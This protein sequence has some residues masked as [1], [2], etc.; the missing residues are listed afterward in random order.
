MRSIGKILCIVTSATLLSAM[1]V[2]AS[3]GSQ[4]VT[5]L[6]SEQT[7]ADVVQTTGGLEFIQQYTTNMNFIGN[8]KESDFAKEFHIREEKRGELTGNWYLHPYNL[9]PSFCKPWSEFARRAG[10]PYRTSEYTRESKG[11]KYTSTVNPNAFLSDGDLSAASAT[12]IEVVSAKANSLVTEEMKSL[13]EDKKLQTVMRLIKENMKY[14]YSGKGGI[15]RTHIQNINEGL[16]VCVDMSLLTLYLCDSIGLQDPGVARVSLSEEHTFNFVNVNGVRVFFDPT[17]VVTA[18]KY[19]TNTDPIELVKEVF[20]NGIYGYTQ[21]LEIHDD[22]IGTIT[23][24][25][26]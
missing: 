13:P 25:R 21:L 11:Y 9:D 16:G 7:G 22:T 17:G 24:A 3:N 18:D 26:N 1:P 19:F 5:T 6:L 14:D 23:G 15:A 4:R 12:T 10:T 2:M 20:N 8:Y